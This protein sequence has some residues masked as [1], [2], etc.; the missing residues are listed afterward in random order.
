MDPNWVLSHSPQTIA[1]VCL[2]VALRATKVIFD[3]FRWMLIV[4]RISVVPF[5]S[6]SRQGIRLPKPAV[7]KSNHVIIR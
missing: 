6:Y 7:A 3:I 4:R 1:I 5:L 2:A